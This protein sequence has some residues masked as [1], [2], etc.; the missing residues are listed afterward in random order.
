MFAITGQDWNLDLKR[1][2]QLEEFI[3]FF[4]QDLNVSFVDN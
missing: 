3:I 1:L 2:Q 4:I